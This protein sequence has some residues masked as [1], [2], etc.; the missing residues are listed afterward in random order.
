MKPLNDLSSR[1]DIFNDERLEEKWIN[2]DL[3]NGLIGI[4]RR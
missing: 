2:G 4:R 3:M 1:S